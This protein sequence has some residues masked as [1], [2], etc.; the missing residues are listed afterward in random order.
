M[1]T[2]LF[3]ITEYFFSLIFLLIVTAIFIPTIRKCESFEQQ[4]ILIIIL[5]IIYCSSLGFLGAYVKPYL[6]DL[7]SYTYS[8]NKVTYYFHGTGSF[9]NPNIVMTNYHVVE[10]CKE[11]AVRDYEKTYKGKVIS[12]LKISEGDIAFIETEANKK[13]FSLISLDEP[14]VGEIIL[15]PD[16]TSKPGIFDT[17]K[18]KITSV[19]E[20]EIKF[21]SPKGRKGNSGSPIYNKNGYLIGILNA[22]EMNFFV[23]QYIGARVKLINQ[24]ANDKVKVNLYGV[25]EQKHN[26]T[27]MRNFYQNYAVG[28]LCSQ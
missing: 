11:V 12:F 18:G 14:K 2:I 20:R 6:T 7:S 27:K 21:I 13:T 26:L 15:Y 1:D 4:R 22:G 17:T 5:V 10:G 23:S 16:Y 19:D 28:I 25:K 3:Y 8:E 9:V 24:L